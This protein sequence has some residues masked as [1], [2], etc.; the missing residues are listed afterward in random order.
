M[1]APGRF[2]GRLAGLL[3]LWL[4]GP[5]VAQDF[6]RFG[7]VAV[8]VRPLAAYGR[9]PQADALRAD[10]T[11]ALQ[12]HFGDRIVRGGPTL[13]VRVSGLSLTPYAG[14]QGSR[15]GGFG[16]GGETDYLEG[17]ALL[18]GPNGAILA[19]HPQL[20]ALPSSSGGAWYDPASE[21]RRVAALAEHYAAWL[22]RRLPAQ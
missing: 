16:G 13:V 9:G 5:A 3:A 11:A 2:A 20:S 10:L 17:E 15:S 7:G 21:R 18:V 22:R 12:R 8:D 6:G 4:A 1:R 19:R 14:G